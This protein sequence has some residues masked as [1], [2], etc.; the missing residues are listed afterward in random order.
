MIETVGVA[1]G[2]AIG[3]ACFFDKIKSNNDWG[4]VIV[5][6]F[7]LVPAREK[8]YTATPFLYIEKTSLTN[9]KTTRNANSFNPILFCHL[10]LFCHLRLIMSFLRRQ[11]SI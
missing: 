2:F 10:H 9:R 3:K 1:C 11:E 4:P 5:F 7:V 6:F 8:K